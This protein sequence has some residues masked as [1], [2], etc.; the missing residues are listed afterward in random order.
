MKGISEQRQ[1][2]GDPISSP[3]GERAKTLASPPSGSISPAEPLPGEGAG[4]GP[5]R[6][7][8][9]PGACSCRNVWDQAH[10]AFFNCMLLLPPSQSVLVAYFWG[11][12]SFIFSCVLLL[13]GQGRRGTKGAI[14]RQ[15]IVM[16]CSPAY[17]L[18]SRGH[19][20]G[21]MTTAFSYHNFCTTVGFFQTLR[22]QFFSVDSG[23]ESKAL[24]RHK[25]VQ[26]KLK[27][28]ISEKP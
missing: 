9:A 15:A 27:E 2:L 11:L 8:T 16:A 26:I 18:A 21:W 10:A 7:D 17:S 23:G 12:V 25:S 4:G 28:H 19:P 22:S 14:I 3:C 5:A 20:P 24:R 1:D 13:S 6:P